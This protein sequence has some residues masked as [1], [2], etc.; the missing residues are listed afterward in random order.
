[1]P[2]DIRQTDIG[3]SLGAAF[4]GGYGNAASF[5]LAK[6]IIGEIIGNLVV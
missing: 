1:V 5:V 2:F 4:V 6:R 3:F